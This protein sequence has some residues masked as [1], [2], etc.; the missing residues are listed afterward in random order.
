MESLR[1][2]L[3]ATLKYWRECG[4]DRLSGDRFAWGEGAGMRRAVV[5]SGPQESERSVPSES[6]PRRVD[7][8]DFLARPPQERAGGR[9]AE[10]AHGGGQAP[11]SGLP[12]SRISARSVNPPQSSVTPPNAPANASPPSPSLDRLLTE[13]VP[14]AERGV[15]FQ[16]WARQVACCGACGLSLTRQ[17]AVYG[18]GALDASIVWIADAPSEADE[19][20]GALFGDDLQGFF[21]GMIRALG[22][23]RSEVYLTS[24]IKCRPPGDRAPRSDEIRQCQGYWIQELET[25]RPKVIVAMGKGAVETLLGPVGQL[26]R[27]RGRLHSW[28]GVPVIAVYHPAYCLRTPLAKRALWE[29]LILLMKTLETR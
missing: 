25:I 4:I 27:A 15:L 24:I 23:Q 3:L 17:N 28:R 9:V 16:E 22:R 26:A 20:R 1:S 2:E 6:A 21:A 19:R 10:P 5:S 7:L 14:V 8:P 18:S 12:G 13:P 11:A 29:D